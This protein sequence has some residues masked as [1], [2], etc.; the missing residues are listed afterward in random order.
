MSA[1]IA[2]GPPCHCQGEIKSLDK[3][4]PADIRE[5]MIKGCK[6]AMRAHGG[7]V[8]YLEHR[9]STPD[10]LKA[11]A[12]KL[13]K[14][15]P[16][17]KSLGPVQLSYPVPHVA[18]TA[19]ECPTLI[20]HIASLSFRASGTDRELPHL[21]VANLLVDELCTDGFATTEPLKIDAAEERL[22]RDGVP[23]PWTSENVAHNI[24]AFGVGF[25]KGVA[26][27]ATLHLMLSLIL[28]D[29]VDLQKVLPTLYASLFNIKCSYQLH[30]DTESR[31][32][33]AFKASSRGSIRKAPSVIS[34]VVV[35]KKLQLSTAGSEATPTAGV[36]QRWN[37]T[38]SKRE[39]LSGAKAQAIKNCLELM[40]ESD[41]AKL[42]ECIS[43]CGWDHGPVTEEALASKKIFPGHCSRTVSSKAWTNK[44]LITPE[45]SSL[46][47][48]KLI[49]THLSKPLWAR[50][51]TGK[52]ILE[53]RAEEAAVV[54]HF[55]QEALQL[56]PIPKSRLQEGYYDKYT[57]ND[58]KLELEI[59]TLHALKSPDVTPRD[60]PT[61]K[62]LLD[63]HKGGNCA[64]L[65]LVENRLAIDATKLEE[66][67]FEKVMSELSFDRTVVRQFLQSISNFEN[68][69]Y[70]KK[71]EWE[72]GQYRL[73]EEA[74]SA[75][76]TKFCSFVMYEK[77]QDVFDKY[78]ALLKHAKTAFSVSSEKIAVWVFLNWVAPS[79]LS[80]ED[81]D[82]QSNLM[83]MIMSGNDKSMGLVMMPQFTYKKGQLFLVENMVRQMLSSRML[84]FDTK[85]ALNFKEKRDLRDGRPLCY[86]GRIV[87]PLSYNPA[88]YLWAKSSVMQGRCEL[89]DQLPQ[90]SMRT[91]EDLSPTALPM[92]TDLD[93]TIRGAMKYSQIGED[94]LQKLLDASL[95]NGVMSQFDGTSA[96]IIGDLSPGVGGISSTCLSRG[97]VT[98]QCPA[99]T[100]HSAAIRSNTSGSCTM[101][102]ASF[103]SCIARASCQCLATQMPYKRC[104]MV[105]KSSVLL[106][107]RCTCWWF[108][109]D[110][111]PRPP[112]WWSR[113]K[114]SRSGT[115]IRPLE[116]VSEAS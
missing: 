15:F 14:L 97:S 68:A 23:A 18:A 11:Y 20:F 5:I 47:W 51:K 65:V 42:I 99:S 110:R 103:V 16:A 52:K 74:A 7:P 1:D 105:N 101:R 43:I 111:K 80:S 95:D 33:A 6:D 63:S 57:A 48:T 21:E 88:D 87:V 35:L 104:L 91:I 54:W 98:C 40:S 81:L 29:D 19:T 77:T 84:N 83:S 59:Q 62:A 25:E 107:R 109:Q 90:K 39:Q 89:A 32:F 85:F 44:Q 8:Q 10:H 26:R 82:V 64:A 66:S 49:S 71:L 115:I 50:A 100:S 69:T 38:A 73:S 37:R 13:W 17:S 2:W 67:T 24:P 70:A 102:P 79:M 30:P 28:D 61:L 9:Y 41:S 45:S 92:S 96:L 12:A 22:R 93:G 34:W 75:F 116:L 58:P 106:C 53:D 114:S 94:G 76:Q 36:V 27:N 86:D 46:M 4:C 55:G 60:I 113:P 3:G 78:Q 112:R 72:L 31:I 108:N 56:V